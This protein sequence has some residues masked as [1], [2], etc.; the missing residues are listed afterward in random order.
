MMLK[1]EGEKAT[2]VGRR[3]A[4][5]EDAGTVE[6]TGT[7]TSE[8]TAYAKHIQSKRQRLLVNRL[9]LPGSEAARRP[10]CQTFL[11]FLLLPLR[12]LVYPLAAVAIR[13][14]CSELELRLSVVKI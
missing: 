7:G 2:G 11:F 8:S 4:W 6:G 1:T 5:K 13:P 9:G 3:V 14:H 10:G 12:N